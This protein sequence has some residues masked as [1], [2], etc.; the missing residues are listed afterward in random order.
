MLGTETLVPL[1]TLPTAAA[2]SGDVRASYARP[3][4]SDACAGEAAA[5]MTLAWQSDADVPSLRQAV[6]AQM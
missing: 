4:R 3:A 6:T 2:R 1:N 5:A